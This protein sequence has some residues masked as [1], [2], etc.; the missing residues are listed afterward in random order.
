MDCSYVINKISFTILCTNYGI[1][2]K[3]IKKNK[4]Y[5]IENHIYVSSDWN[6]RV[7]L[8]LFIIKK[9]YTTIQT[10]RFRYSYQIIN[11]VKIINFQH[12]L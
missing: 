10:Y 11:V 7:T 3:K 2:F 1:Q 4:L 8:G 12:H 5:K 9:Y 6:L